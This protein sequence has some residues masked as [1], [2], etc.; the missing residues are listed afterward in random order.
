MI[1]P[2]KKSLQRLTTRIVLLLLF[3]ALF[4]VVIIFLHW[5]YMERHNKMLEENKVNLLTPLYAEEVLDVIEESVP[6]SLQGNLEEMV[7]SL[8]LVKDPHSKAPIFEGV[9]VTTVEGVNIVDRK[10]QD[11]N[12]EGMISEMLM[13]SEETG[14][15]MGQ[16]RLYYSLH[17]FKKLQQHAF[18]GFF[19]WITL[20]LV[21][22]WVVMIFMT[23]MVRP[24]EI[25][26][27]ALL[28]LDPKKRGERLPDLGCFSSLEIQ[29]VHQAMAQYIE[30]LDIARGYTETILASMNDLLVVVSPQGTIERINRPELLGYKEAEVLGEVI[31]L[32]MCDNHLLKGIRTQSLLCHRESISNVETA[33]VAKDGHKI[34]ILLSGSVM[35]N[36]EQVVRGFIIVA[37]DISIYK[38]AQKDLR[39]NKARLLAAEMLNRTKSEFL[40]TMSHEIRTPMNAVI[41]MTHLALKTD[42]TSKQQDYLSKIQSSA[43]N[44]L[45]IINDILDFSKIEAG[46]LQLESIAFSLDE[47]LD[48][49]A[50]VVVEK[51]QEKGLELLISVASDVPHHLVGDPLRLSQ[52]IINLTSN[53]I[54]FTDHGEVIITIAQ[55]KMAEGRV[56]LRC[57][58]KD[59]GIGMREDQLQKLFQ[60][61]SQADGSTTRKYGGTG[62]GLSISKQL[63]EMMKGDISVESQLKEGS[64]FIFHAWFGISKE[65]E[66][67]SLSKEDR[68]AFNDLNILIVD[69]N[70]RAREIL[71]QMVNNLHLKA[72][73]VASAQAGLDALVLADQK[74]EAFNLVL[75]DW[76]MPKMDG[77]EATEQIKTHLSLS[78]MPDVIMV[79][80]FNQDEVRARAET[81]GI[82]GFLVKPV[83]Q[84]LLF[85]TLMTRYGATKQP[86]RRALVSSSE[87]E[88]AVKGAHLLLVEDNEI[89]QQVAVELLSSAGVK[90][91]VANHGREALDILLKQD[92]LSFDG[93]LMDIQMPKM[94]GYEATKRIRQEKKFQNLPIIGLTA[95]AMVEERQRCLDAGMNDHVTKPI[96]PEALFT[97]LSRWITLDMPQSSLS[98]D[99]NQLLDLPGIDQEIGLVRVAGNQNL[100]HNLL[101]RF[102]ESQQH[103]AM[104]I[105]TCVK[106]AK[107][108]EAKRLIHTAKGVSGNIGAQELHQIA[109][110]IEA[111]ILQQDQHRFSEQM[112]DYQHHLNVVIEGINTALEAPK[113]ETKRLTASRNLDLEKLQRELIKLRGLLAEF[114]GEAEEVF[115]KIRDDLIQLASPAEISAFE[116][117]MQAFSF[118]EAMEILDQM[119]KKADIPLQKVVSF[120]E[121]M[122]ILNQTASEEG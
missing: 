1:K 97:A 52:V 2:G 79:T 62:L 43:D 38:E 65:Q 15:P 55:V 53:A 74:G 12:F 92:T 108:E 86:L 101:R 85:D 58:V 51:A 94:D 68:S 93:I 7:A 63:V 78:M 17:A 32:L 113:E 36:A 56:K 40:A 46:K 91:T 72:E 64:D 14:M 70:A 122:D 37:K 35:R 33:M 42:L 21:I 23:R 47:V 88:Q 82:D 102:V 83:S 112:P 31:T 109:K 4:F 104:E 20:V 90:M 18:K 6:E 39:E 99:E 28:K 16:L 100:Y 117:Q 120:E 13:V 81:V 26:S 119:A 48:N 29:Q 96:D 22:V 116:R 106:A 84:S 54:K 111:I 75:M 59:T 76:H 49:V 30:A 61:F 87:A 50:N 60:A 45:G 8:M 57:S 95:H 118:D 19:S 9:V 69:D 11:K 67:R 71:L 5:Q 114:D 10:P 115:L 110:T 121:A 34:P 41:G 89:N 25:L 27:G 77:I 73:A 44:L 98:L 66:E 103:S 105:Q 3:V 107:W 24:L 80:A